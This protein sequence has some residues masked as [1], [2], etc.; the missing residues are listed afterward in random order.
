MKERSVL[1]GIIKKSFLMELYFGLVIDECVGFEF[2]ALGSTQ[3]APGF[4]K[5]L[6]RMVYS[7]RNGHKSKQ[8]EQITAVSNVE[9]QSIQNAQRLARWCSG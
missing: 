5:L 6:M 9:Q 4:L 7:G 2:R 8:G 3:S 1:V